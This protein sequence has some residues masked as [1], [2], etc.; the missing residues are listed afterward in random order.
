MPT[1][2]PHSRLYSLLCGIFY[3]PSISIISSSSFRSV[4]KFG[5]SSQCTNA[6]AGVVSSTHCH[7]FPHGAGFQCTFC[8][9]ATHVSTAVLSALHRLALGMQTKS[10][11]VGGGS[12]GSGSIAWQRSSRHIVP[13]GQVCGELHNRHPSESVSHIA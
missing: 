1:K 12:I 5:I 9:S 11:G 6:F 13:I 7:P 2:I 3:Y 8:P 10:S 4:I